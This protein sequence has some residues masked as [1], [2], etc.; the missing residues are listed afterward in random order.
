[1]PD[2]APRALLLRL[3]ELNSIEAE[4]HMRKLLFLGR[5]AT[6]PKMAP[7]LR[8]FLRSRT[9]SLRDVKSIGILP[10]NC[11]ALN[12]YDL[13]NYFEIWFNSSTS[14]TYGNWKSVAKNKARDLESR[15]WMEFCSG[16]PNM[17]VAQAC[18]QNVSPSKFWSLP[19]FGQPSS[20]PRRFMGNLCLNSGIRWLFKT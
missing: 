10:S 13:F 15:L 11:E 3:T 16:H 9:E 12:K 6:E 20:Y 7:S 2:F 8:N 19:G 14:P 1:M 17:H 4:I 18:L 5:L